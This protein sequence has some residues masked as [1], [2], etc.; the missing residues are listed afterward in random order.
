MNKDTEAFIADY[1]Q[2]KELEDLYNQNTIPFDSYFKYSGKIE[3][4]NRYQQKFEREIEKEPL[5]NGIG[6][7]PL[8]FNDM[9]KYKLNIKDNTGY[10]KYLKINKYK[11]I[12]PNE[13]NKTNSSGVSKENLRY[14]GI[15]TED[16]VPSVD[17]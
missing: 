5:F 2:K 16:S 10:T 4:N 7:N 15:K 6:F 8:Y 11:N 14:L 17:E 1:K 3:H 9:S 13:K 12:K